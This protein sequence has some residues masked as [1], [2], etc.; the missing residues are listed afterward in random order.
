MEE[1]REDG[2]EEERE[3][4]R[5]WGRGGEQKS[6]EEGNSQGGEDTFHAFPLSGALKAMSATLKRGISNYYRNRTSQV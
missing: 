3:H 1:K 4:E 2:R 5:E 6:G